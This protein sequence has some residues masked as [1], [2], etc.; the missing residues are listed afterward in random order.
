MEEETFSPRTDLTQLNQSVTE[1]KNALAKV[2]VGQQE[3]PGF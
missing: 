2:V 3:M 1:I